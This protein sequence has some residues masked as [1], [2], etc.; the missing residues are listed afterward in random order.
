MESKRTFVL[1]KT[2]L[3]Q[4]AP[5]P[6]GTCRRGPVRA[7]RVLARSAFILVTPAII[8]EIKLRPYARCHMQAD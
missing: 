5:G 7:A 2:H 1:V 6:R 8:D 3:D 4:Q